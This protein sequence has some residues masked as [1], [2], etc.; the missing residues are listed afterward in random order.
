[1]SLARRITA[2]CA[3]TV[4]ALAPLVANAGLIRDAEIE[5]TLRDYATPMLTSAGIPPEDVRIFIVSNPQINAF[6]AGGLNIF[7]HTG[8]IRATKTPDELIGVIAHE[9]GHI[10]GAHLSQLSEKSSRAMLGSLIGAVVG[11]VAVAGGAGG[12]GAGII[13][14]S[15]SM[16]QRNFFSDIRINEQSA[17]QAAMR[18]LDENEISASGMLATFETLRRQESGTGLKADPYMRTHPMTT[19]R[20]AT[21][22]NHLQASPIPA[23]QV[24]DGFAEKHARMVAK[25]AAFTEPYKRVMALY[26]ASDGS[27]AARYARAIAEFRRSHLNDALEGIDALIAEQPNDAFFYDTKGQILFENGKLD[28]AERAY[29]RAN[30]L[31]PGNPLMLTD[32]AR[33]LIARERPADLP[34]AIALLEQSKEIDDSYDNTWRQLAIA[35]GKQGKLGLSYTAL[36]E[37][38]A[39]AGDYR[40]VL[41]HVARARGFTKDDPSLAL[42]LDDLQRDAQA[43]LEKKKEDNL[44]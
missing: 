38:S 17:D 42:R 16:A 37:E 23:G 32:H 29:A 11:A 6:V 12:A 43:Q 34:R 5:A 3:A 30:T 26:P 20:I 7:I 4:F 15:Q 41:Q 35:Y 19:E 40:T 39:L 22:R 13:A 44:F 33:T 8:M 24:P 27:V 10:E 1:M 28:E 9:T 2:A 21:L 18:Y 31:Q 14:G 25:L 36:A